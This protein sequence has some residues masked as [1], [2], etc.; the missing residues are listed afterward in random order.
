[1]AYFCYDDVMKHKVNKHKKQR[2]AADKIVYLAAIIEPFFV[3]PQIIQIFRLENAE[4][5][6]LLT[7]VGLNFLTAIWIWWAILSKEKVI[8][9]YQGMYFFFNSVVILGALMYNAKWI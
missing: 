2:S 8:V 3:L 1:M 7:W 6:S 9:I 4:S 5:I